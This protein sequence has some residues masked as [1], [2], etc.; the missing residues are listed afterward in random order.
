M[1][2]YYLSDPTGFTASFEEVDAAMMRVEHR[3]VVDGHVWIDAEFIDR[4]IARTMW[5]Q[6]MKRGG[7]RVAGWPVELDTEDAPG[8]CE[9][10]ESH[11]GEECNCAALRAAGYTYCNDYT[12]GGGGWRRFTPES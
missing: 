9:D 10:P 6:S 2:T 4:D 11:D 12:P 7:T 3:R 5:S 8:R 1:T